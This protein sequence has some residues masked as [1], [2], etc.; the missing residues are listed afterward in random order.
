MMETGAGVGL[1]LV[2]IGVGK[3]LLLRMKVG[4]AV[5]SG[6]GTAVGS[7]VGKLAES[8]GVACQ[9]PVIEPAT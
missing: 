8:A 2:G 1:G 7:A 9:M 4:A 3:P 6:I 5:V